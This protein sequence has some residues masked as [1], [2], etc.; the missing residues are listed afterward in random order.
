M[1][2]VMNSA[3][4]IDEARQLIFEAKNALARLLDQ[5]TIQT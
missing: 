1:Q 3:Y 2:P 5:P 4:Q